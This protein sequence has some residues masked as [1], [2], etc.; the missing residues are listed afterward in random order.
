MRE[1]S[2][3]AVR[4]AQKRSSPSAIALFNDTAK[5]SRSFFQKSEKRRWAWRKCAARAP[6]C[7]ETV[8]DWS[9]RALSAG[10]R[11]HAALA[12]ER[13]RLGR[14]HEGGKLLRGGALL[15][16]REHADG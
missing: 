8:R 4:G 15:R 2:R 6:A 1:V 10:R 16:D 5:R 14:P 7:A 9:Q 3:I 13:R 12:D 11:L